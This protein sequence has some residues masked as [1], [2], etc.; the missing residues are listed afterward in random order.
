MSADTRVEVI[1]RA[2]ALGAAGFLCKP[3][4]IESVL[5]MLRGVAER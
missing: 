4:D 1:D 5:D 3:L 2:Q